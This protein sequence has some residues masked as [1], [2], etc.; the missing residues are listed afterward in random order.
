MRH[1]RLEQ[2][3]GPHPSVELGVPHADAADAPCVESQS[4]EAFEMLIE[5]FEGQ[6]VEAIGVA[7]NVNIS[8]FVI[9]F[10]PPVVIASRKLFELILRAGGEI[11]VVFDQFCKFFLETGSVMSPDVGGTAFWW[12][13][14]GWHLSTLGVMVAAV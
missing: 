11:V 5:R 6:K 9:L 7:P 10:P 12:T 1:H 3:F 8:L 4:V 14:R 13:V 2:V